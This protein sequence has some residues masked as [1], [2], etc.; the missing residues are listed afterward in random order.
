MLEQYA[1]ARRTLTQCAI[2]VAS[3]II[4]ACGSGGGDEAAPS[5]TTSQASSS[6]AANEPYSLTFAN[7]ANNFQV[8]NKCISAE[9]QNRS[10][11][12]WQA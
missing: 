1:F 6:A 3:S 8:T 2:I 5:K 7:D 10:Y 9:Y 11:T 4:A 12:N